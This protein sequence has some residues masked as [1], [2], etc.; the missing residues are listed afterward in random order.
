MI[1]KHDDIVL[2]DATKE[3]SIQLTK[4]W[5]DGKV[6]SHAGFPNGL[7]ITNEEV[8]QN[9]HKGQ[10]IIEYKQVLIGECHYKELEDNKASIGIKICEEDYQNKGLGKIILS[11]LIEWLFQSGYTKIILDTNLTNTRAQHV[12][13]S[14][15]FKK[16]KINIDSWINAV[17]EYQSSVDY[18]L[19][20]SDFKKYL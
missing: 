13:E 12:Y 20:E 5:N 18:E 4:W 16:I 9:L 3:D 7:G 8:I 14:L 17:G 6:M 15:G 1:I 10:L 11:V 19:V 2:R